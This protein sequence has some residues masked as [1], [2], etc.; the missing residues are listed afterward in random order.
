MVEI[1]HDILV[2]SIETTNVRQKT[3]GQEVEEV[4]YS[5]LTCHRYPRAFLRHRHRRGAS[6]NWILESLHFSHIVHARVRV[7]RVHLRC[8]SVR[9]SAI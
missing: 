7:A 8:G 3:L 4:E 9:I 2:E 5:W 1:L 6:F